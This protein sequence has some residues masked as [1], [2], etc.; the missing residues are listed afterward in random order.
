MSLTDNDFIA[1]PATLT[2]C[3]RE[4]VHIPRASQP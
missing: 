3:D 2:N 1:A 4:P